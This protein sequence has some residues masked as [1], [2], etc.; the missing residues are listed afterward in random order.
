MY[1]V[2]STWEIIGGQKDE[3]ERRGLA[4][5]KILKEQPGVELMEHFPA[6]DSEVM[7]II[8]YRDEPTYQ[9]L[10]NDPNVPFQKGLNDLKLEETMTWKQSWRGESV[11]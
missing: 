7:V 3:A 5:R 8:G 2:A 10:I 11:P 9:R 6:T 4:M 1:I